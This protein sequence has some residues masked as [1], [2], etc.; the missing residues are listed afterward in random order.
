[1][2]YF[3]PLPPLLKNKIN[4]YKHEYLGKVGG[5]KHPFASVPKLKF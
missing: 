4:K 1:M 3:C 5:Q 2:L